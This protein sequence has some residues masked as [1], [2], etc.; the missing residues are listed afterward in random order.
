MP[1]PHS[2]RYISSDLSRGVKETKRPWRETP[3][4]KYGVPYTLFIRIGNLI[5]VQLDFKT[6]TTN[7]SN[8]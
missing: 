1:F 7:C 6:L 4:F 8:S 3:A 2:T 5:D